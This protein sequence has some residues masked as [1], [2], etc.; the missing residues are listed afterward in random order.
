MMPGTP[1]ANPGPVVYRFLDF[2]LDAERYEFRRSGAV[3]A[4]SLDLLLH[5]ACHHKRVVTREDLFRDVWPGLRLTGWVLSQALYGGARQWATMPGT[6]RWC[7]RCGGAASRGVRRAG[8]QARRVHAPGTL[9][10]GRGASA[11]PT[12]VQLLRAHATHVAAEC[13]W[14][15]LNGWPEITQMA[16]ELDPEGRAG[17]QRGVIEDGAAANSTRTAESY[18][19]SAY[20]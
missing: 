17:A 6:S 9:P 11:P 1:S 19:G 13:W 5:L 15:H 10:R 7:G 3:V 8:A 20:R 18:N 16:P 14:E 4:K 2:E 12:V